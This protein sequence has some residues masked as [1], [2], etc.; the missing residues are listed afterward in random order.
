[1]DLLPHVERGVGDVDVAEGALAVGESDDGQRGLQALDGDDVADV[2][3]L[4]LQRRG[5]HD[6][7]RGG[8]GFAGGAV[9]R[10]GHGGQRLALDGIAG[11][12]GAGRQ[13]GFG[14]DA[15]EGQVDGRAVLVLGVDDGQA[16][17]RGLGD[18]VRGG[19][20]LGRGYVDDGAGER[21]VGFGALFEGDGLGVHGLQAGYAVV[22]QS[23]GESG[24]DDDEDGHQGQYQAHQ[25]ESGAREE[26]FAP[27]QEHGASGVGGVRW[28]EPG[29]C[30]LVRFFRLTTADAR[31]GC[32]RDQRYRR[33]V[34]MLTTQCRHN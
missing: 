29:W 26:H 3:P 25:Q 12:V 31:A 8:G 17:R 6:V 30:G 13:E 10:G 9:A 4:V 19:D 27:G 11:G 22:D 20:V 23:G 15:D 18:S 1:M 32:A 28:F 34:A 24:D 33:H 21:G 2:Q 5:H 7:V 14:V 16:H